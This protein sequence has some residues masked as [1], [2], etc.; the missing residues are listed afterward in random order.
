[1][2]CPHCNSSEFVEGVR[3]VDRTDHGH[4]TDLIIETQEHPEAWIF[5]GAIEARLSARVCIGCGFVMFFAKPEDIERLQTGKSPI[6]K[7]PI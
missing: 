2:K 7:N 5:K 1:M 3:V 4:K 6:Q